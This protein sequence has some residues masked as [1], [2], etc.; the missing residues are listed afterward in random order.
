MKDVERT[1][2]GEGETFFVEVGVVNHATAE[3][4]DDEGDEELEAADDHDPEGSVKDV[5]ALGLFH[6][7]LHCK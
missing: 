3:T 5:I 7:L 1:Y 2:N 4:D 6:G